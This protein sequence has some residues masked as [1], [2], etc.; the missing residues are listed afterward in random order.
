M[1]EDRS[2]W[3]NLFQSKGTLTVVKGVRVTTAVFWNLLLIFFIIGLVGLA[4]AGGAGAGYFAS[5]VQD[6]TVR[7]VDELE[8]EIY[9]YEETTEVYF[10]D[11]EYLGALPT[12]LERREVALEDVSDHLINAVIATEDEYF[13]EHEG[14]VP[15]AL[16]R[17]VFQDFSNAATQTGG[18]T[19]TQQLVKNQVLTNEVTH[20]RKA[21]EILLAMRL[22]QFME[23]DEIL[24]AYLNI[25]PF[26]RNASGRQIAGAEAA[27]QGI[28]GVSAAELN[29]P[30]AAFIAG[31]PQSPFAYTPFLSGGE[32]KES[33]DA[34]MNRMNTVLDRMA[35]SEY[36]TEEEKQEA[37][38][39]DIREAFT[40]PTP[41][42]YEDYPLIVNSVRDRA[43][44]IILEHLL[45]QDGIDLSEIED[46]EYRQLMINRYSEAAQESLQRDGYRIHT[47]INKDIYDGQQEAVQEFEHFGPTR[48]ATDENEEGETIEV[49]YPEE[50]GSVLLDNKTGAILSFVGG[51]DFEQS[52]YNRAMSGGRQS[53]STM[54]PLLTYA[55]G[56]EE[57]VLQPGFITPDTPYY[58]DTPNAE[59]EDQEVTNFD[60]EHSGLITARE[61][62]SRSRNVPAVRELNRLD[63]EYVQD[64]MIDF[65]FEPFFNGENLPH[66]SSPLGTFDVTVEAN[67][68]AY[69][70]FGNGGTRKEPYMIQKIETADG[71]MVFEQDSEAETEILSPQTSYLMIDVMRDVMESGIGTAPSLPGYLDF[72]TDLAGKTGTTQEISD[73]WFVGLNPNVTQGIWI[74]YDTNEFRVVE[75]LN[76]IRYGPRTQMLWA[77]LANAAYEAEPDLMAPE[78][79]FERPSGIVEE[80]ICGISGKLPSDLCRDAGFV[81]TDLFNADFAPTEVDDS[82]EEVRYVRVN[83]EHYLALDSTPSEFTKTG[84][85]VSDE[86]FDLGDE[87][88]SEYLPED[89]ENLVSA[90][91]EA[92]DNGQTPSSPSISTSSDTITWNESSDGDVVGYRVYSSSG[93]EV[94]SVRWDEDY[95]YAGSGGTYYITAVDV[96]GRESGSSNEVSIG[97]TS[98]NDDDDDDEDNGDNDSNENNSADLGN[99]A[100]TGSTEDEDSE[101]AAYNTFGDDDSGGSAA[102]SDNNADNQHDNTGN[103]SNAGSSNNSSSSGNSGNSN[104]SGSSNSSGGSNNSS[105]GNNNSGNSSTES[106]NA[107]NNSS[108]ENE[109][110]AENEQNNENEADTGENNS[111]GESN[112]EN[113]NQEEN[114]SENLEANSTEP[115]ETADSGNNSSNNTDGSNNNTGNSNEN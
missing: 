28:F 82:L 74:G 7:Q 55:L 69:S 43:E 104:N 109:N 14:I 29:I 113:N 105:S 83:G 63:H 6:E 33:I 76:G 88:I 13:Y 10:A 52:E 71:E 53:G 41:S 36:I 58:Y 34:A 18:S 110:N 1:S 15:K 26:G 54:K 37:L 108:P 2:S 48:T 96:A 44:T 12:T 79:D 70:A 97:T 106:S 21:S 99:N 38:D 4:F 66:E 65:G 94:D 60:G 67:T 92:P 64:K 11:E 20:D 112:D 27:A 23:K 51:R 78:E 73:S 93:S 50:V 5:L 8:T 72:E 84:A 47:T 95:E 68:S 89:W 80:T 86:Y 81:T 101:I 39:Y 107:G 46:E 90:D 61:A 22:E 25:V 85:S 24:E 77:E 19:L 115:N 9:N 100:D 98:G 91:E 57:G 111:A 16:F 87:D 114:S 103:S 56:F 42:S 32:Q 49:D 35:R 17:A 102:A 75:E 59:G 3:K 30:Q 31:L 40:E 62:L 45:E